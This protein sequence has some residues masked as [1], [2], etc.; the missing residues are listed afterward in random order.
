MNIEE[1][2][3]LDPFERLVYWITERESIRLKKEAG[4][5]RPWTDDDIL[6]TYR[7]CNVRR[8]DDRVSQWL[9]KNWYEPYRDHKNI[10]L[11]CVLA[12]HFNQPSTL[13]AIGFPE[14]WNRQTVGRMF[15][16]VEK[17]RLERAVFNGAYMIR[18]GSDWSNKVEMVFYETVQQFVPQ[19]SDLV[20]HS[21]ESAVT[22]FSCYRNLGT[23][24]AGQI[25]ADLRWATSWRFKD[26]LRWAAIGPGSRRGMNRLLGR[27]IKSFMG[28]EEFNHWF[29]T[30]V[31][32]NVKSLIPRSIS[33]RLEAI[34]YQ[35]CLCEFDK[36]ERTLFD[37]RR[38]KQLYKTNKDTSSG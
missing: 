19:L 28:Q 8:M 17:L 37:G 16:R 6:N 30:E 26:R 18:A 1:V 35:N 10:V 22:C 5:P 31:L 3:K 13:E 7:F 14:V 23:F 32:E 27:D 12:R 21:V 33:K 34:D 25:V 24:M 36:Y 9:L 20:F 15:E 38:P 2:K 29:G 4:E 11:A